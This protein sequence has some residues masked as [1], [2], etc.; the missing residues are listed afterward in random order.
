MK[1]SKTALRP[2]C[3]IYSNHNLLFISRFMSTLGY[4]AF[5]WQ[6]ILQVQPHTT[7]AW[8]AIIVNSRVDGICRPSLILSQCCFKKYRSCSYTCQFPCTTCGSAFRIIV[9]W[10]ESKAYFPPFLSFSSSASSS[11]NPIAA[12]TSSS[13]RGFLFRSGLINRSK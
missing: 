3:M 4:C 7:D 10:T 1:F 9:L 13:S 11:L 12:S 8:F 2:S 5:G 6:D